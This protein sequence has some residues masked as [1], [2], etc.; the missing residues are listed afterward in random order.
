MSEQR[1][2]VVP[3]PTDGFAM[4]SV[5]DEV[6]ICMKSS[7]GAK[8]VWI[9]YVIPLIVLLAAVLALSACG[10]SELTVGLGAIGAVALYYL[11]ILCFRNKLRNEFVFYIK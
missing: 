6:D 10:M 11:V 8:A 2:K 4:R 1:K 5:G 9:S 3:V 7:M